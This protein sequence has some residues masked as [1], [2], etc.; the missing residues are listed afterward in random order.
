MPTVADT[1]LQT[2]REA[3]RLARR[4]VASMSPVQLGKILSITPDAARKVLEALREQDKATRDAA[5]AASAAQTAEREAVKQ[6]KPKPE[7]LEPVQEHRLKRENAELKAQLKDALSRHVLNEEYQ[8][9]V[10]EVSRLRSDPPEWT[11]TPKPHRAKQAMPVAHLSD[12]HF[13]EIV[14]PAQVGFVNAYDRGIAEKR[15]RR[16]TEKT[17]TLCDEYLA[18]VDYP[19]MVLCVS[20]D[21]FSGNIHE[22]LRETNQAGL[23]ASFRYWIDPMH[24][25]IKAFA[26]RFHRITVH[27]VVGNHPRLDKKPRAKGGVTENFDWLLGSMLQRD[28]AREGDKRVSF[29]VSESF[30]HYFRVY[31]TRYLQTHGD[32]FKGGTG[33]AA[34]LSPLFIGDSRKREKQQAINEPYDVLIMGH[35]HR[36][37][38]VPA[39]DQG[40][41]RAEGLG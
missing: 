32:Q 10:A 20:G 1:E 14:D 31:Q 40:Q 28:F 18:G 29:Q 15:L 38:P 25:A 4:T 5:L 36:R 33:I 23:C 24:A 8:A 39:V 9:F 22:E 37:L 6:A 35:W 3:I 12:A 27:W 26:E 11:L 30:D 13:D 19:G 17:I 7:A 21:M 2:A 41:W 34:E 16:F